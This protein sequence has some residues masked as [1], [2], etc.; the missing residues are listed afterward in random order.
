MQFRIR[1]YLPYLAAGI[2]VSG[3][4]FLLLL[5][6]RERSSFHIQILDARIQVNHLRFVRGQRT[7]IPGGT[8]W[9]LLAYYLSE[10]GFPVGRLGG[11]GIVLNDPGQHLLIGISGN[12]TTN[13]AAAAEAVVIGA[14]GKETVRFR[15]ASWSSPLGG[16]FGYIWGMEPLPKP[17]DRV[18]IRIHIRNLHQQDDLLRIIGAA[19]ALSV[20]VTDDVRHLLEFTVPKSGLK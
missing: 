3:S 15:S 1:P 4:L 20:P 16:D 13:E 11:V 7:L 8:W 14:D 19:A 9:N 17:G 12:L 5:W 6:Q 2:V 18:Q 10:S